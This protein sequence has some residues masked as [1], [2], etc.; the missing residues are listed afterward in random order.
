MD[1]TE[2]FYRIDQLLRQRRVVPLELFLDSLEV[3]RATF[4][5]DLE[6][7]RDRLNAP[8]IWDRELGGYRF[9]QVP[10][11]NDS[12]ALPG[13]WFN[14]AEI[15][16]LLSMQQLLTELQPG[17]LEPHI[18]PL[19]SRI[20]ALLENDDHSSDEVQQRIRVLRMAARTVAPRFFEVVSSALLR[21]R[22]LRLR[23]YSRERDQQSDR[24]VS[25]QRL[26]HYRDNWYLDAWCHTRKALRSF[27][28]DGVREAQ[29]LEQSAHE[30]SN[31]VLA[32]ELG[33]GY[34]IFA[35]CKTERARLRFSRLRARW[36]ASE[37]WHPQQ[38]G[39]YDDEGR[40]V[41]EFPFSDN[42]EL[43][44]DVLKHGPEVEVLAPN[45]LREAVVKA[46]RKTLESYQ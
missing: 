40:Y 3:S 22:R 2:R 35:G 46:L 15:H 45:E 10:D 42:R 29:L 24:D 25:P 5:R 30:L 44:M 36:V 33:A 8:I 4:K 21:R 32:A 17:L 43:L 6:Y 28:L 27:S 12:Y 11:A 9:E 34:G 26:V 23:H 14:A 20:Q 39:R 13:L 37:T 16:A 31:D 1:R 19:L 41:L 7:L 38:N 18:Q